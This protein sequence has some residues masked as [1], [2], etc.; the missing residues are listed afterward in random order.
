MAS[1]LPNINKNASGYKNKGRT[2]KVADLKA[3]DEY[4]MFIYQLYGPQNPLP[5]THRGRVE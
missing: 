2:E 1:H 5:K 4:N 3:Q